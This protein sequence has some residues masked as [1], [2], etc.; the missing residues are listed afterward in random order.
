[1]KDTDS[2]NHRFILISLKENSLM[3][4]DA[5]ASF[6][7]L[8][9][10]GFSI[11]RESIHEKTLQ[12]GGRAEGRRR[13]FQDYQRLSRCVCYDRAFLEQGYRNSQSQQCSVCPS[14]FVLCFVN[15]SPFLARV[16]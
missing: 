16:E 13:G 1:M 5:E 14:G 4:T 12:G 2:Y 15:S 7:F 3:E 9:M 11:P 10:T 6:Q 8:N